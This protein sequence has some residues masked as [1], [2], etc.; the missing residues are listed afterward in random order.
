MKMLSHSSLALLSVAAICVCGP[1]RPAHV[2]TAALAPGVLS[3][4]SAPDPGV[5]DEVVAA[6]GLGGMDGAVVLGVAQ[7]NA[8][9][10]TDNGGTVLTRSE[11]QRREPGS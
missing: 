4:T 7:D 9:A 11:V 2:A 6:T 10:E 1:Q 5:P 8:V 3:I